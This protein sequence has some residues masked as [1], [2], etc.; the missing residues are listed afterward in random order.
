MV[1][2]TKSKKTSSG[3]NTVA[4]LCI[5]C[6]ASFQIKTTLKKNFKIDV[7]SQCHSFYLGTQKFESK[8]GRM[9]RFRKLERKSLL[10][11]KKRSEKTTTVVEDPASKG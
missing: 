2:T 9:E 6:S 11:Q 10:L 8:A 7:C 1:K 3:L 4:V 5:T